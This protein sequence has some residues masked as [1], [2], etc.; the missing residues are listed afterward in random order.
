MLTE[1][2]ELVNPVF[3]FIQNLRNKE[4]LTFLLLLPIFLCLIISPGAAASSNWKLIPENPVVGDIMEIRGTGFEGETAEVVVT[5]EKEVPVQDGKYEYLLE[6][7]IIPS[8][9]DNRFTVQATGADDL[10]VRAKM[11]LWITKSA[12]AKDGIAIVSQ[13]SVPPGKYKIRIDGKSSASTVKLKIT[14]MQEV[15]VDSGG[16]LSYEYNTKS[17]PAGNFEVNV[18]SIEKQIELQPAESLPS[19]TNS[20]SEQNLSE[21]KAGEITEGIAGE[22]TEGINNSKEEMESIGSSLDLKSQKIW[23]AGIIVGLILLLVYI[24][25]KKS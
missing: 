4:N 19:E 1:E 2:I 16:S 17:I 8:G 9:F 25:R 21:G 10:N 6:D 12:E 22:I 5:F 11:L 23:I 3:T 20:S 18:G 13:K 7:I 15:E 14:A 24:R